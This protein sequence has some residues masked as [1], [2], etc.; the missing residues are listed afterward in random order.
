MEVGRFSGPGSFDPNGLFLAM[1]TA[2]KEGS[3]AL[4]LRTGPPARIEILA[5]TN[6]AAKEEHA[7]LLVPR[8]H[9]LLREAGADLGDLVGLVVGAGPGSFTG[10][11]VG[12]ATAKGMAWAKNRNGAGGVMSGRGSS[13][14]STDPSAD[15]VSDAAIT[16][17]VVVLVDPRQSTPRNRLLF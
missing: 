10:V 4:A 11:R 2:G 13:R 8:I 16:P 5:Q 7:S 9:G 17:L 12:A 14:A 1:D 3:L 15:S 6:L